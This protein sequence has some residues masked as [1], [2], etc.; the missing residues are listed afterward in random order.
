MWRRE[1]QSDVHNPAI[2]HSLARVVGS[3]SLLVALT[4]LGLSLVC[5]ARTGFIPTFSFGLR[6]PVSDLRVYLLLSGFIA[7][8][9]SFRNRLGQLAML[10]SLANLAWI[11]ADAPRHLMD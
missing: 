4:G 10:V 5:S 1:Q 9:A 7:G 6:H 2:E 3:L 8:L 11:V